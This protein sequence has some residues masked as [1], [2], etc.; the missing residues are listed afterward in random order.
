MCHRSRSRAD[1]G[2]LRLLVRFMSAPSPTVEAGHFLTLKTCVHTRHLMGDDYVA[3]L[4]LYQWVVGQAIRWKLTWPDHPEFNAKRDGGVV[5]LVAPQ[6]VQR[7]YRAS[8]QDRDGAIEDARSFVLEH[9][10]TQGLQVETHSTWRGATRCK[11]HRWHSVKEAVVGWLLVDRR[12]Q[13]WGARRVGEDGAHRLL[14]SALCTR[15]SRV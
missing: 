6:G 10:N 3:A 11:V 4:S 12:S 5:T 8:E 14:V 7:V 13:G 9:F 15:G 1:R 2:T